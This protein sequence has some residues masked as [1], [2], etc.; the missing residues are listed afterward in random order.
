VRDTAITEPDGRFSLTVEYDVSSSDPN[1]KSGHAQLSVQCS[2]SGTAEFRFLIDVFCNDGQNK[3]GTRMRSH[4]PTPGSQP[5][6]SNYEDPSISWGTPDSKRDFIRHF[7]SNNDE[8][9]DHRLEN[10]ASDTTKVLRE[11]DAIL[12]E[13]GKV[14]GF[15]EWDLNFTTGKN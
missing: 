5:Q 11:I 4:M 2:N 12:H 7:R 3:I 6:A 1:F 15:P 9:E 14:E 8:V 13:M 10:T